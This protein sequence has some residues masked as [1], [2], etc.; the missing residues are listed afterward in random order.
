M[1]QMRSIKL[2]QKFQEKNPSTEVI[3]PEKPTPPQ[4]STK[5][6][7][8]IKRF[9]IRSTNKAKIKAQRRKMTSSIKFKIKRS[10]RTK[11]KLT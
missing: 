1:Y 11:L 7:E 2:L 3:E 5:Q 6:K 9:L 8:S 10:E 4:E